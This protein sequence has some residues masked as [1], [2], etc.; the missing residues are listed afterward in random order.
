[1]CQVSLGCILV[2]DQNDN[3]GPS[4]PMHRRETKSGTMIFRRTLEPEGLPLRPIAF[5]ALQTTSPLVSRNSVV[6]A[7]GIEGMTGAYW[8]GY[9]LSLKPLASTILTAWSMMLDMSTYERYRSAEHGLPAM[10]RGSRTPTTC[11]APA[12][13]ANM[14]RMPVPQPT[15]RTTLSLKRWGF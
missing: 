11:F 1:M 5:I 3:G 10:G 15:S 13:A 4:R 7:R 14:L 9:V 2:H 12:L 6:F 8:D